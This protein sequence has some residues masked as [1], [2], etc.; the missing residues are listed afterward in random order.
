MPRLFCQTQDES[1]ILDEKNSGEPKKRQ[2]SKYGT[3]REGVVS[4]T[5]MGTRCQ[6]KPRSDT[7]KT[8]ENFEA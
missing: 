4:Y 1:Q 3:Q 6:E 2:K 7:R 8:C 5:D